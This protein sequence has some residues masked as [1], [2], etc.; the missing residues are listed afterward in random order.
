MRKLFLVLAAAGALVLALGLAACGG[1]D[2]DE[3]CDQAAEVE[4]ASTALQG[5]Q[6]NDIQ[7]AQDA[8]ADANAK[9]QDV[10]DSAPS[11]ISDDVDTVANFIDDLTTQ[12]QDAKT[13]QDFLGLVSGLQGQVADV[14]E[15]SDNVDQYIA[16]NC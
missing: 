2:T 12:V 11:E 14:Q 8:L 6:G 5:L 9:V 4:S 7:A 16:D 13:P 3:F 1:D 10:A 15:A